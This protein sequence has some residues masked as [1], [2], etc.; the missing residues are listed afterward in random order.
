MIVTMESPR[1]QL[2]ETGKAARTIACVLTAALA[3]LCL[4]PRRT[5]YRCQISGEY[6]E[7][8]CCRVGVPC[9]RHEPVGRASCCETGSEV[10]CRE[11]SAVERNIVTGASCGCCDLLLREGIP[12]CVRTVGDEGPEIRSRAQ[13][14][15]LGGLPTGLAAAVSPRSSHPLA[16]WR[17][18]R[19]CGVPLYLLHSSFIF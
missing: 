14:G 8:C 16:A 15:V 2:H 3:A 5:V 17:H 19:P 10:A 18:P 9:L 13:S 12:P 7:D 11:V 1:R 4:A 6:L